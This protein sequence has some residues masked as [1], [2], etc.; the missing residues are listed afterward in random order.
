MAMR[1]IL[2]TILALAALG[3]GGSAAAQTTGRW[4]VDQA[5]AVIDFQTRHD[6][7]SV[8]QA[9]E[10][11]LRR[12]GFRVVTRRQASGAPPRTPGLFTL[13][14]PAAPTGFGLEGPTTRAAAG[15]LRPVRTV[16]CNGAAWRAEVSPRQ[17]GPVGTRYTLCLFPYRDGAHQGHQL[18]IYAAAVLHGDPEAPVAPR[19][20][21]VSPDAFIRGAVQAVE[22]RIRRRGV[23]IEHRAA[24]RDRPFFLDDDA[25][26][27]GPH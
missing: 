4:T 18:D 20:D 19:S 3:Q 25:L 9:L 8:A 1:S 10:R 22:G 7:R 12:Q 16:V 11:H 27:A 24:N 2:S 13:A 21:A 14:D 5:Y 15:W 6:G 17:V 26:S 23:W